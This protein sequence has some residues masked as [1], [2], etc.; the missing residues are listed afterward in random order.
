MR[1]IARETVF[2][3]VFASQF[4][5]SEESLKSALYKSDKL[6]EGD[7]A[8]CENLINLISAHR[9]EFS[10][11]IDRR[12]AL[13][14]EARLFA[15]DRSILFIALAEILYCN[16]IPNTVSINEAAN[17]ASKYS[18]EKSASFVS[19]ILSEIVRDG[20]NV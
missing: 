12:S 8:Y 7:V 4:G 9:D 20:N 6:N 17:I 13:F 3:I 1:T 10:A 18:T 19:G 15:A 11:L 16:D 2:K 14:P 5:K